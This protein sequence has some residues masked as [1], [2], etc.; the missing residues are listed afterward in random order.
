MDERF[1][2]ISQ[3]S[4]DTCFWLLEHERYSTWSKTVSNAGSNILC[5]KGKPGTGKSSL[6]KFAV[7]NSSFPSSVVVKFFF[8]ARGTELQKTLLGLYRSLLHQLLL[9]VPF[10]RPD[11]RNLYREKRQAHG[12]FDWHV[13]ELQELLTSNLQKAVN[14][15]RV[16]IYIDALDESGL[17]AEK[18]LTY[19]LQDLI[20][21]VPIKICFS[22]R[23]HPHIDT[24]Q[25]LE[26]HVEK[27]NENDIR[28]HVNQIFERRY[29]NIAQ[30]RDLK[31]ID[32]IEK[33]IVKR[34]SH[35]FL[36]VSL[37][38]QIIDNLRGNMTTW[39]IVQRK[40]SEVPQNLTDLYTHIL[41]SLDEDDRLQSSILL[42]WIYFSQRPLNPNELRIAMAFDTDIPH[43]SL[44]SWRESDEYYEFNSLWNER[45]TALSGGLAEVVPSEAAK[46]DKDDED[47]SFTLSTV[48]HLIDEV[49]EHK[50]VIVQFIH[51]SVKDYLQQEGI[52]MLGINQDG[53]VAGQCHHRMTRSC[54]YYIRCREFWSCSTREDGT[55]EGDEEEEE[56]GDDHD[57]VEDEDNDQAYDTDFIKY[58]VLNWR[59]HSKMAENEHCSQEDILA[60]FDYP[61]LF[62][63]REW[64]DRF[65]E[66][67]VFT[68]SWFYDINWGST[69]LHVAAEGNML[70]LAKALLTHNDCMLITI[71]H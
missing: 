21:C 27:E 29:L 60:W 55:Y 36:W 61:S 52:S 18:H 59:W 4:P 64:L 50:K 35:I 8:H 40:I 20:S 46:N 19:Y 13:K 42:R 14:L 15:T 7:T 6:M 43:K 17:E 23:H 54:I 69:L 30:G 2:D 28:K 65:L 62:F 26:I 48:F 38:L 58:A 51:E 11:F 67:S 10:L 24:S 33:D 39:K 3:A 1:H 45:I 31:I 49:P 56:G 47:D 16:V 34:S 9:Q 22:C 32:E 57:D 68:D 25:C 63:Y 5:I 44:R 41:S 66:Y 70:S 37:I 71:S 12:K 53:S